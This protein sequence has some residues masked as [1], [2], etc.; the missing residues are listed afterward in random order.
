MKAAIIRTVCAILCVVFIMIT[1]GCTDRTKE[2]QSAETASETISTD[3]KDQLDE[4][5]SKNSFKGVVQITKERY[6]QKERLA[7]AIQYIEQHGFITLTEYANINGL[8]RPVASRELKAF[9]NDPQC[10]IKTKG[11]AP[12]KTWVI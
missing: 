11:V 8:S 2:T 5:L 6:I 3:K 10:P 9:T 4:V 1:A 12:H 7:R